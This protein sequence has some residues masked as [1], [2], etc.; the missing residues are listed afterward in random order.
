MYLAHRISIRHWLS[1][2]FHESIL[3]FCAVWKL[4]KTVTNRPVPASDTI[5]QLQIVETGVLIRY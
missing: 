4:H 3:S 5:L 1:I 2:Q